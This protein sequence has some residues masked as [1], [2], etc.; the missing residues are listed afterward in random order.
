MQGSEEMHRQRRMLGQCLNKGMI[1]RYHAAIQREA[2]D[3]CLRLAKTPE[4]YKEL[5]D[6]Y[7]HLMS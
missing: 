2:L 6:Q 1:P 7:V 5:I 4:K 3:F